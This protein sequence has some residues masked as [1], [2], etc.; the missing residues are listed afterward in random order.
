MRPVSLALLLT[1]A[2]AAALAQPVAFSQ[3]AASLGLGHIISGP[4]G[5]LL[6]TGSGYSGIG[7]ITTSG[8]I[9]NFPLPS[10]NSTA[11]GLTIGPDGAVWFT[12]L[13]GKI[14]H[15]TIDGTVTEYSPL[16]SISEGIAAGP[17]GA[18]W[19]TGFTAIQR[20]T[21]AGAV[22]Q[23]PIPT[24]SSDPVGIA[25]GPDGALWFT[26][27]FGNNIGRITTAGVITEFPLPT[28]QARPQF[29]TAGPD[30]A[31]WFTEDGPP[32]AGTHGG[33]GRITTGGIIT[34]YPLPN[35][36]HPAGI[37]VGPDG[38]LWFTAGAAT[39]I[40][41]RITTTGTIST[42]S[43]PAVY[44]SGLCTGPDNA[45]WYLGPIQ[46]VRAAIATPSTGNVTIT[47]VPS[48]LN[49][50]VD[51]TT[52]VA[53]HSFSWQPG[54]THSISLPSPQ[55]AGTGTRY[56]FS[57]W[58]DGGA[59]THTIT[60]PSGAIT[61]TA[62]MQAQF[63]LT[64]SVAPAG[65]GAVTINPPAADGYYNANT[66]VT[67]T[68][69]PNPGYR[70]SNWSGDVLTSSN[71]QTV[72]MGAPHPL[73]ANFVSASET[74]NFTYFPGVAGGSLVAGPDG[75]IWFS[76]VQSVGTITTAGVITN[77]SGAFIPPTL[78]IGPDGAVWAS[79]RSISTPMAPFVSRL[80]GNL[81]F[82]LPLGS[83]GPAGAGSDGAIWFAGPAGNIGR[84]T[85]SGGVTLFP[86]PS[87]SARVTGIAAGPDG[88]IWFTES[89]G[90]I[91]RITTSGAVTEFTPPTTGNGAGA[92]TSGP[93]GALRFTERNVDKI[94]RITTG[95]SITEYSILTPGGQLS[96]ITVGPD[97]ALWFTEAQSN[98]LG[99]IS[100]SGVVTEHP[101]PAPGVSPFDIIMGSDG[102][103]W[104]SAASMLIR[105]MPAGAAPPTPQAVSATNNF[106][107]Q[108]SDLVG[109]QNLG[110]VDILINSALDGRSAC[111]LAYVVASGTLVLVNDAGK[112]E[113][114]YAGSLTLGAGG[115]I[116]NSQC[117]VGLTSAIG[118]GTT[119]TLALNVTFLP[120]FTGNKITYTA[121]R[122]LGSGTSGWQALGT[123]Q[124]PYAP[125]GNISVTSLTPT[126][127]AAPSATRQQFALTI[128][129]TKGA[130]DIGV[131]N[132][133]INDSI[134]GRHACYLAYSSTTNMLYLVDDAGDAGGPFAGATFV[135]DYGSIANSQCT[136]SDISV[137]SNIY[138]NTLS[139]SLT[140]SFSPAFSGNRILYAAG[141][142]HLDGNNTGW[143][144]MGT[145]TIR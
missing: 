80:S 130:A 15:I 23:F 45:I 11:Q 144:P 30:G 2:C 141:R 87:L 110:V 91:G 145:T 102:A 93:D 78:F 86:L 52:Y 89:S 3:Y 65:A 117:V 8:T 99:R 32:G 54:E 90:A 138:T 98:I 38:A 113:G 36:S 137:I 37:T 142:D 94:G 60:V 112:S 6:F 44:S 43:A 42:Y 73:Q 24:A 131:V 118:A 4:D 59:Q 74:I 34:E 97:G 66:T 61:Y 47:T 16:S 14:G 56:V 51:N 71:P 7:R 67:A 101:I 9:T 134:D 49:I 58:S 114:P 75:K 79:G 108:F 12:E 22:S 63:L 120:A 109:Y 132:L 46:V 81:S 1:S 100:I 129:D 139:L 136:A 123:L 55:S 84:I 125:T 77:Q 103:L 53:P 106:T 13:S 133:L 111:Y 121:A 33:I 27:F 41:G 17:D 83:A 10:T 50:T 128:T 68:A 35:D 40:L 122:D 143:Q 39:N 76:N 70:F 57:T 62:T 92:I 107:F 127:T 5:A 115:T 105:A 126:R 88:A 64:L 26:E 19:I 82:N 18:L 29:I 25:A 21:T 28:S 116:Q 72:Y 119:L 48:G 104:L 31:L 85:L 124:L 96:S 135:N 95:G 20:I 140:L 69:N